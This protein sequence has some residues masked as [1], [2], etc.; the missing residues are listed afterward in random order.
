MYGMTQIRVLLAD[1]HP[2]VR[3]GIRMLLEKAADIAVVGEASDGYE[4][5]RMVEELEPDVLLLDME[6]PGLMGVDV[7][8]Q[9]Q[10][11]G[12]AVRILALSAHDDE[13]Y[14]FG[15]LSSGAIGYMT[16]DEALTTITDAVRG[17]ASGEAGWLSRRVTAKV[18]Q[19]KIANMQPA[20]PQRSDLSV[21]ERQVL[22]LVAQGYPNEQIASILCISDGTVKNHVTNIYS[23]LAV[24]TRAEAVAWAW[25]Q[26]LM[27]EA[28]EEN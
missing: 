20:A 13:Q 27:D 9:L 7:A 8:R 1:D 25:K 4:A 3:S 2:V 16:K 19:C 15:L 6:M 28:A 11:G 24:R 21:R 14:I 12:S 26:G 17:V 10:E 5:L 22:R 23:K 18:L